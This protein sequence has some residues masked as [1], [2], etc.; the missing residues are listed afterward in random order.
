M[1]ENNENIASLLAL[2]PD[3][4]AFGSMEIFD[5]LVLLSESSSSLSP[6]D[7]PGS[8]ITSMNS[9]LLDT[10]SKFISTPIH[11]NTSIGS[12]KIQKNFHSL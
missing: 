8:M 2:M 3:I 1:S 5:L 10:S 6:Q 11:S 9:P 4:S 12:K 7:D